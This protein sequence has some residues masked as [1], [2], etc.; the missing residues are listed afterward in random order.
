MVKEE[1]LLELKAERMENPG[2]VHSRLYLGVGLPLH[3]PPT[4]WFLHS[5]QSDI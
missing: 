4:V 1:L 3:L 5:S 2:Q